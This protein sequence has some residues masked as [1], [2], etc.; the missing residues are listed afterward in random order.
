MAIRTL[1]ET[2]LEIMVPLFIERD[3]SRRVDTHERKYLGK[4]TAGKAK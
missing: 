3:E 2:G 1:L 4:E